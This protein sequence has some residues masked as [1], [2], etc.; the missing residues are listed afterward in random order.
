MKKMGNPEGNPGNHPK[1]GETYFIEPIRDIKDIGRIEKSLRDEPRNHLLFVTGI[2]NGLRA[3]DLVLLRAGQF[4]NARPGD[5]VRIRE[6]KTGKVSFVGITGSIHRSLKNYFEK[7]EPGDSDYLF[8]SRKGKGQRHLSATAVNQMI[9]KWVREY[10]KLDGNYGAHTLRKTWGYQK[11]MQ[12][13]SWEIISK[14]LNHSSQSV[15][16]R[17]LGID[18]REVEDSVLM[19]EII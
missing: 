6:S 13:V 12:G 17:Y 16:M 8:P 15:T 7:A 18:D 4:R 11:R 10:A 19:N 9:K 5:T 2:N 14:R 1:K 3:G